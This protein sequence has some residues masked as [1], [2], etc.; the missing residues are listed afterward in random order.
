MK[1]LNWKLNTSNLGKFEEFK[2]LF[3][4]FGCSLSATHFDLREIDADPISVITH[5][6]S[7]MDEGI[8][9]D[10]TSLEIEG[11]SVGVNIRWLL[12][13]LPDY[14]GRNAIW[15]VLL[16]YH[17]NNK[18]LI[19]KGSISGMIVEPKGANGFGFDPTFLPDGAEKTLAES[20]PDQFSARAAA[21]EALINGRIWTQQSTI[22]KWEGPWQ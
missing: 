10:D 18:V 11:A 16:A 19:Y 13:H 3:A 2:C 21:V 7:Q 4:K 1:N 20:K 15:T 12:N 14:I 5:K 6:A 8:I 22:H 9:V 17:Q